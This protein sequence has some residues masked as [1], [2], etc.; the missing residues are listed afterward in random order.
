MIK[1]SF[2]LIT[3]NQERFVEEAFQSCINQNCGDYEI[4]ISDDNSTDA[5]YAVLERLVKNYRESVAMILLIALI[6]CGMIYALAKVLDMTSAG[7]IMAVVGNYSFSIML[8]HFLAFK[9]VNFI[10]CLVS[11]LSYVSISDFPVMKYNN[12]LWFLLYVLFGVALPIIASWSFHT[13]V[14]YV[15]SRRRSL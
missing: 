10:Q 14:K 5:T 1:Y 15:R 4:V 7:R 3:Y 9:V 13:S 12:P 6:G 2:L 8:L 11:G